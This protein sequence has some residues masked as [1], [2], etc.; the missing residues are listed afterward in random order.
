MT[1]QYYFRTKALILVC[2][3]EYLFTVNVD[4]APTLRVISATFLYCNSCFSFIIN[5][6]ISWGRCFDVVQL[7]CLLSNS[8][9]QVWHPSVGAAMAVSPV[10]LAWQWLDFHCLCIYQLA[11]F[12]KERLLLLCM[13]ISF[14]PFAISVNIATHFNLITD[15]ASYS[16]CSGANHLEHFKGGSAFFSPSPHLVFES[17]ILAQQCYTWLTFLLSQP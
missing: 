10:L 1:R 17:L 16:N 8:V 14:A 15:T 6:L 4:L 9:Y 7:S 11:F 5:N 13:S 2:R 3:V 12:P